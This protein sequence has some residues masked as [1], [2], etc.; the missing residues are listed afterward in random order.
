[1]PSGITSY[2]L[3][4]SLPTALDPFVMRPADASHGLGTPAVTLVDFSEA[5]DY[6]GARALPEWASLS[7][8]RS[9]RRSRQIASADATDD[10]LD[11]VTVGIVHKRGEVCG[12][13]ARA[14]SRRT[15]VA[16]AGIERG[17]MKRRDL[18]V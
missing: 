13:R 2:E 16:P 1:M 3:Y 8:S 12:A 4:P 5:A 7:A 15:V 11:V 18:L 10:G 9:S 14:R 6:D 17:P